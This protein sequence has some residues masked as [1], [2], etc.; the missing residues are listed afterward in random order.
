[1]SHGFLISPFNS[2]KLTMRNRLYPACI[3]AALVY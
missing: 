3:A 1:L 2:K